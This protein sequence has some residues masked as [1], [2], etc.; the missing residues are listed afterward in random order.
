MI[1]K[2]YGR[3]LFGD[4]GR[5]RDAWQAF[6]KI[7]VDQEM[8]PA[9]PAPWSQN[10]TTLGKSVSVTGPGTFRGSAE[11]EISFE[12]SRQPGWWLDRADLED[13]LP[14]RVSV[15]NVWNTMRNIVLHCGSPH[16]YMRMAEHIIALRTGL[17]L[18]NVLVR[19]RSGDPPLFDRGSLDLV[20]AVDKAGIVTLEAPAAYLCVREPVTAGGANGGFLT[21]LPPEDGARR[22]DVDC[23]LDFPTAIGQQRIRFTAG[24]ETFRYGAVAR[25]NTTL[26]NMLFA[27]TV[28]KVFADVRNLGYT[29]RNILVAGSWGYLNEPRLFHNGKSLEAA[30][31]RATLD[32][33]AAIALIDRGRLVGRVVS[34]K[35]GHALDVRLILQLYRRGLLRPA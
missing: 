29:R 12:P 30:W 33:L 16:N 18:D 24:P 27:K 3:I 1:G 20:E 13:S 7:P 2:P 5:I 6:E 25:T 15:E 35:A 4:E 31:H 17:G 14:F 8:C 21:F 19:L 23:A 26:L 22:L 10:Q 11:R 32:L 28:G 9:S 34:F